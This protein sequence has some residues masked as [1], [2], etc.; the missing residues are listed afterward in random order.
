MNT[1]PKWLQGILEWCCP[2]DRVD[3]LG[4]FEEWY[5]E[6]IESKGAYRT[7]FIMLFH[8]ISMLKLKV[9]TRSKKNSIRIMLSLHV[10]I[11]KRNL[12]KNK[13]YTGINLLGLAVG[14]T[15]C[16]LITLFILDELSY[17]THFDGYEDI[18]RVAG[19]YDQGGDARTSSTYTPYLLMPA[20]QNN[21][22]PA[23]TYTRMDFMQLYVTIGEQNFWEDYSV[24]VDSNFFEVFTPRFIAGDPRTALDDPTS[25]VIDRSNAIKFFEGEEALGNILEIEGT[26]YQVTGI[27]E[28]LPNN[29][30]FEAHLFFPIA[31]I[32]DSYPYWLTDTWGGVS[33]LTYFKTP[34]NYNV[35]HLEKSLEEFIAE[36]SVDP[37][38]HFFQRVKD[39][40]LASN[41]RGEIQANGNY[42]TI[43]IFIAT[44]IVILLLACINFINLSIAGSIERLKEIGVKKVLGATRK[45]QIFQF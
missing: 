35:A 7:H 1:P 19:E 25:V 11:A 3:V 24:A 44:A 42:R 38:R 43:Y 34:P 17:D 14:L 29:T 40:H 4:D 45:S 12:I 15:V 16:T 21:L 23:V 10:K 2:E 30:H 41:L 20:M 33:H 37:P 5:D 32:V 39:I 36:Y 6:L 13:L 8:G 31:S 28:D 9:I 18:Y 26:S 22:D 27:I